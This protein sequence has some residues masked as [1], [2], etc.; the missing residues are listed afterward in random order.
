MSLP[1]IQQGLRFSTLRIPLPNPSY[2]LQQIHGLVISFA[3]L[4]SW[5]STTQILGMCVFY[6]GSITAY[7]LRR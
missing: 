7:S 2:H 1:L 5:E 3:I 4:Q 6:R